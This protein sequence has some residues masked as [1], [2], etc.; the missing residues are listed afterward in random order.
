[1]NVGSFDVTWDYTTPIIW[2]IVE[3][4]IGLLCA[5][6]PVMG[7]L[8]PKAWMQN[9]RSGHDGVPNALQYLQRSTSRSTGIAMSSQVSTT[10]LRDDDSQWRVRRTTTV[11]MDAGFRKLW[12]F[13]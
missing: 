3:P 1:M 11:A 6:V 10:A 8:L 2:S 13:T 5:C 4:A 12:A 9:L 7:T